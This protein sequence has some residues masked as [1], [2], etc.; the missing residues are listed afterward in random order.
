[1]SIK[2]AVTSVMVNG[3]NAS[4]ADAREVYQWLHEREESERHG[5]LQGIASAVFG[6]MNALLVKGGHL[7][8]SRD[9]RD[10]FNAWVGL[11]PVGAKATASTTKVNDAL[12]ALGL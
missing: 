6:Q 7:G 2:N 4:S 10:V 11:P 1:M 5:H 3:R 9:E 8:F 12:A